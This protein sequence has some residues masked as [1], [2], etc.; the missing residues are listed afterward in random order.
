M[1]AFPEREVTCRRKLPHVPHSPFQPKPDPNGS[2]LPTLLPGGK[3]PMNFTCLRSGSSGTRTWPSTWGSS[4]REAQAVR[5]PPG[6][7]CWPWS[8]ST[9]P[10]APS[11][12]S[13][14]RGGGSGTGGAGPGGPLP[15][16]ATGMQIWEGPSGR[17]QPLF[18]QQLHLDRPQCLFAGEALSSEKL[19]RKPLPLL[20]CGAR[21]TGASR[22]GR[23]ALRS[24]E[25]EGFGGSCSATLCSSSTSHPLT[26]VCPLLQGGDKSSALDRRRPG[27]SPVPPWLCDLESIA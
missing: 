7:A 24:D 2:L 5:R 23:L 12:T 27:A 3:T 8:Q 25:A 26:L 18:S 4:W 10:A 15:T 17:W 22:P 14:P 16:L 13:S 20:R 19:W 11:K 21:L 1:L 9:V 6:K